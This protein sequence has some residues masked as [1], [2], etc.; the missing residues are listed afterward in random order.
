M[1]QRVVA[2]SF[3]AVWLINGL[4]CKVLDLVPRHRAIVARIL[5]EDHALL[6]TRLIGLSEILMAIWIVSRW[7]WKASCVAQMA[8]VALMNV[9]EFML[10]PDL[11]LFGRYNALIAIAYIGVI[12]MWGYR[13]PEMEPQA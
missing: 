4:F 1:V 6:L 7:R 5:G 8:A 13:Q 3:A 11:L 10:A 9:I 12:Y 2:V